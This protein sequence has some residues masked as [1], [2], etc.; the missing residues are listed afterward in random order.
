MIWASYFNL[1]TKLPNRLSIWGPDQKEILQQ[2]QASIQSDCHLVHMLEV[3]E[4][5]MTVGE[6]KAEPY[7]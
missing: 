3:L 4:V 2:N 5:P 1:C 6:P 7:R